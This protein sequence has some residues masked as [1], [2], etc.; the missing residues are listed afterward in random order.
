MTRQIVVGSIADVAKRSGTSIAE[1]FMACDAMV[2]VDVSGSMAAT[3]SRGGK[4]RYEVA[5]EELAALQA[6]MPGKVAVVEFS[7]S[8]QFVPG[9]VPIHLGG[10][11][12]LAAALRF[13]H[14]IDGTGIRFIVVSDGEPDDAADALGVAATFEGQI[15]TVY[16]GPERNPIGRDFL[17]RLAAASGGQSVT[18]DR[19][20]ELA[21]KIETLLLHA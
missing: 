21:A 7:D 5:I 1:S 3:D 18:A 16:V 15:D 11:T 12:D 14:M 19:A 2:I 20:Q 6:S 13:A 9:G 4:S 8:P 17:L 10:S